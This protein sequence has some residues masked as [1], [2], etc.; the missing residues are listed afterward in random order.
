MMMI[1]SCLQTDDQGFSTTHNVSGQA[2]ALA[3][4]SQ[5]LF[6]GTECK[7]E[8]IVHWEIETII[9]MLLSK[10]YARVY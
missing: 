9:T 8:Y 7:L 5:K 2:A 4:W 3:N 6:A 1:V 10:I